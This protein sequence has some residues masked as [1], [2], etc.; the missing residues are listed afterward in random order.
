MGLCGTVIER[1]T[2]DLRI[3]NPIPSENHFHSIFLSFFSAVVS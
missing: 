2:W 3:T 1:G